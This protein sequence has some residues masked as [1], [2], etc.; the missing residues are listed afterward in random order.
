M[1]DLSCPRCGAVPGEGGWKPIE[2][3]PNDGVLIVNDPEYRWQSATWEEG[4]VRGERRVGWWCDGLW[5]DPQPTLWFDIPEP[6][7]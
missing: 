6:P 7:K 4:A 5:I 2:T 1:Q 3:A